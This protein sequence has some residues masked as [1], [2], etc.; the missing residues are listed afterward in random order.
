MGEAR[1]RTAPWILATSARMT[2]EEMVP[3]VRCLQTI[4]EPNRVSICATMQVYFRKS[5][6]SSPSTFTLAST[7]G[8]SEITL[9]RRMT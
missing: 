4:H 3:L 2:R 1:S 6:A 9:P 5:T 8:V 7:F